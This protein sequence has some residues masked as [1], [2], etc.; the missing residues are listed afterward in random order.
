MPSKGSGSRDD[1]L[2]VEYTDAVPL[3]ALMDAIDEH[4]RRRERLLAAKSEL[5]D[6]AHQVRDTAFADPCRCA[7]W[8]RVDDA[9]LRIGLAIG[10]ILKWW[11]WLMCVT[12]G[13]GSSGW[14]RSGCWCGSRRRTPPR[15]TAWTPSSTRPTSRWGMQGHA[16]STMQGRLTLTLDLPARDHTRGFGQ[17]LTID[18]LDCQLLS[19]AQKVQSAQ[20]ALAVASNDLSCVVSLVVTLMKL[21]LHL[22][23]ENFEVLQS[24]ICPLVRDLDDHGWEVRSAQQGWVYTWGLL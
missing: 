3:D 4:F 5:N 15:C 8:G 17:M 7:V 9:D 21:R 16:P 13:I 11:W 22:D 6:M 12:G 19:A 20:Q 2:R 23:D 18:P 1:P 24:H 14:W 10:L